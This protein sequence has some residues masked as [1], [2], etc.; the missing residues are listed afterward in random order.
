VELQYIVSACRR[1][2]WAFLLLPA[3]FIGLVA[4][5]TSRPEVARYSA[6]TSL[7]VA[8]PGPTFGA[9]VN[10]AD[11]DRY[12][13][14]QVSEMSNP[15]LVGLA[16]SK[17]AEDVGHAVDA[18]VEVTN[19]LRTDLVYISATGRD[20][21]DVVKLANEV[22]NVYLD[23]QRRAL[24]DDVGP[25]IAEAEKRGETLKEELV[26]AE[27]AVF[28]SPGSAEVKIDRDLKLREYE[29]ILRT[30]ADLEFNR[31]ADQ[32]NSTVVD[33]ARAA[34]PVSS[35]SP[36]LLMVVALL[37]GLVLASIVAVGRAWASTVVTDSSEVEE[38]IDLPIAA[39]IPRVRRFP[40][41]R[42]AQT[43]ALPRPYASAVTE[44]AV[45][46][47]GVLAGSRTGVV[48]V[49]GLAHGC[50]V[51]SL[52]LALGRALTRPGSETIVV[53]ADERLEQMS[54]DLGMATR[55]E[56]GGLA[57][58]PAGPTRADAFRHLLTPLR[59]GLFV[60]GGVA[61][62]LNRA[63]IGPVMA[64]AREHANAVV[65]D[66][67][68]LFGSPTSIHMSRAADVIVLII[69]VGGIRSKRLAGAIHQLDGIP[70]IPVMSRVRRASAPRHER[71]ALH[72]A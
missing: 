63:T 36:T 6:T 52:S 16:R 9:N 34:S 7:V 72:A 14:A 48:T 70:V 12:I 2:W 43:A 45:R 61:P 13:I 25:A 32:V 49:V 68:V 19:R 1:S 42:R 35:T 15:D 17:V 71:P 60:L 55:H 51:T 39:T 41:D 38:V 58:I 37:A 10:P 40:H 21:E 33:A 50:G 23:D 20:P 26:D 30:L 29:Q 53:D 67:G 46:V 27:R 44:I 64:L 22:A 69:P 31:R 56:L 4:Y 65:L 3:L 24:G 54:T 47:E 18:S 57:G 5:Q 8:P 62:F 11:P 28:A 59:E 66:G